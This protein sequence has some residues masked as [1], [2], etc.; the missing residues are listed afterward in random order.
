MATAVRFLDNVL[1]VNRYPSP[2]IERATRST[3][4]IGLGIMGFADL[5]IALGIPYDSDQGLAQ[6][7]RLAAFLQE[8]ANTA[9]QALGLERGPFPAWAGSV[10]DPTGPRY[11]NA[12]RTTIAPTGTLSI[13]A[14]CS[15]GV[16]PV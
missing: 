6:A 5:L 15:S 1:E 16:E 2:E 10:F 14:A 7:E 9:S 12:T 8:R 4:K 3:R 13:I 11:R